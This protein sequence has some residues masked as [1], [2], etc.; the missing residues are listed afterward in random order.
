MLNSLRRFL[1]AIIIVVTA[2]LA[3]IALWL[4]MEESRAVQATA[5]ATLALCAITGWYG[6]LTYRMASHGLTQ[7]KQLKRTEIDKQWSDAVVLANLADRVGAA[8]RELPTN[9]SDRGFDTSVREGALWSRDDLRELEVLSARLGPWASG[10]LVDVTNYLLWID[11]RIREIQ[12]VNP[13][14]GFDY[15]CFPGDRWEHAYRQSDKHLALVAKLARDRAKNLANE[16]RTL[17][18]AIGVA[19]TSPWGES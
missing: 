10:P 14:I 6:W 17:D 2:G 19:Q 1:P 4:A 7:T 5:L 16:K 11:A 9:T 15:S 18:E 13:T 8:L 12:Q 3:V